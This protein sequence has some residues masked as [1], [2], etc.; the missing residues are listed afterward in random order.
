MGFP[1]EVCGVLIGKIEDNN[2]VISDFKICENTNHERSI[3]RYELNPKDFMSAEKY[4]KNH[5][6]VRNVGI[7]QDYPFPCRY[8]R[9]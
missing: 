4:A 1:D 7:G 2:F 5:G 8:V 6:L 3:D 9:V